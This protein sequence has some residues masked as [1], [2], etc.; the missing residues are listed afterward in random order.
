MNRAT[1]GRAAAIAMLMALIAWNAWIAFVMVTRLEMGDF[2]IF[3]LSARAQIEGRDMYQ[4]PSELQT[5]AGRTLRLTLVNLNPPHLQLL[6]LPLGLVPAGVALGLWATVSFLCLGCS[7]SVI[8]RELNVAPSWSSGVRVATWL[9]AFAGMGVVVGTGEVSFVLLLPFT[10]AWVAA[11]QGG[12]NRAASYLGLVMSVKLFLL[13]FIPYFVLKRRLRAALVSAGVAAAI[14]GVGALVLGTDIYASWIAQLSSVHWAWRSANASLLGILTRSLEENPHFTPLT[15]APALVLPFW[16]TAASIVAVVT[17]ATLTF[18]RTHVAVD[19]AFALLLAAALLISPLGWIYYLWL[20][21]GPFAALARTWREKTVDGLA[22]WRQRFLFIAVPGLAW[23]H[24]GTFA[25]QPRAW[26]TV[27]LASTY[28]WS[29]IALWCASALDAWVV[30]PPSARPDVTSSTP[31]NPAG[32]PA[33]I[34]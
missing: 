6:L 32:A 8:A 23:P 9:L 5:Y 29:L 19:R 27:L 34:P 15:V 21:L 2:R 13:V 14:F 18:D 30:K 10:L 1:L 16:V 22:C 31:R 25:F 7:L 24:F 4:L 28:S 20:G 26:A 3:Y 17:L 33:A 12:W 11:R